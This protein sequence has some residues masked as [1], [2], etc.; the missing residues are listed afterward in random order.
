[1]DE[2][3]ILYLEGRASLQQQEELERWRQASEE[4][5]R[6]FREVEAVW[7]LT[8][9]RREIPRSAPAPESR[10]LLRPHVPSE[11][12]AGRRARRRWLPGRAAAAAILVLALGVGYALWPDGEG[13]LRTAQFRAGPNELVTATLDDGSV[14]RL[15]PGT[16]LEA[17]MGPDQREVHLTGRAFF[18][19][20]HDS[21]RAFR[22]R[23]AEGEVQVLGTR[24]E[25][26]TRRG[27]FRL[28]V[29]DGRV[30]LTTPGGTAELGA[31][32]L[33]ES[34]ADRPPS[35]SRVEVPEA[36]LDW[37]GAWMAFEATPLHRV[38]REIQVRLGVEI[39]ITDPDV[40]ER[41]VSGWFGEDE[42]DEVISMI[43]RVADLQC[44]FGDGRVRIE[45]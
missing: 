3:I 7:A 17:T 2:L 18:A 34:S 10:D 27:G 11:H 39:E 9:T 20:A 16:T 22:V 30:A 4:H 13:D 28:L 31:G 32:E 12:P 29:V 41:T 36:L 45:G 33:G 35:V 19:V 6:R 44:E 40:A 5:E 24:F 1:M 26:D 43:C 14:A 8:G 37:M 25:V 23:T 21:E 15:A 38:A 42:G